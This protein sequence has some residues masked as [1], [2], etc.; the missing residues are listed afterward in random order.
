MVGTTEDCSDI[1]ISELDLQD[2]MDHEQSEVK[3]IEH[4]GNSQAL[5]VIQEL[6]L[7]YLQVGRDIQVL[8]LL[9][10]ISGS[11]SSLLL[12]GGYITLSQ[13]NNFALQ[14]NEF[15]NQNKQKLLSN[16]FTQ[17]ENCHNTVP[18]FFAS[19]QLPYFN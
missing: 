4:L 18:M 3:M 15:Q 11:I 6:T 9:F 5:Q 8:R 16:A 17:H 13:L 14:V 7:T 2:F 12:K 1:D 10:K 19:C